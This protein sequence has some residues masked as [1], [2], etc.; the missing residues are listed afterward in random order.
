M[1]AK[2]NG[3]GDMHVA[4]VSF[5]GLPGIVLGQNE[6]I[7]WGATTTYFDFSDV[8]LETLSPDGNGVMLNGEEVPFV[9]REF[10]FP[11][12]GMDDVVQTVLYVPHHGPVLSI[13]RDAGT[14][15]SMSW[16]GQ[17]ATTDFNFIHAMIVATSVE[18]ARVALRNS[19]TIGQNFVVAGRNGDIGWF[20]YSA[21]PQRPWV[22]E[23]LPHFLP[24]PG[25]GSAEWQGAVPYEDLPQAF[26][27]PAAFIATAN[28]DMTGAFGDG[29]PTNDNQAALQN[30][31]A[32]GY[33]HERIVDRLLAEETHSRES[34]ESILADVHSLI[35][36]R[37]TPALLEALNGAELSDGAQQVRDALAAWQFDCPTGLAGTEASSPA[38]T[39][40]AVLSEA[41]GCSAFHALWTRV[42]GLTFSDELAAAG[43]SGS[44]NDAAL[45]LA[46]T[47][48]TA[49]NGTY[50]D[51]VST[52]T[53]ETQAQVIAT[54]ATDAA[55]WLT[56]QTGAASSEWL[57]GRVHTVTLRADL[58]DTAGVSDF[59]NGPRANDG[60][61]YTV[62]VA[63]PRGAQ[64]LSHRSGAS[65]RYACR[66]E[67]AESPASCTI[68]IPG[69]QRNFPDD[70]YYGNLFDLWL[71][72][73]SFQLQF[74]LAVARTNAVESVQLLSVD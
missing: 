7:A 39:D 46:L 41:V 59:N 1:D 10:T 8:Y 64:D 61:L 52:D 40:T 25:D 53:V 57:W 23:S 5:A 26:N 27:P 67:S 54:A 69:G 16:T 18:E 68:Q 71:T 15:V 32:A 24:L 35:G 45:V 22:S 34:M 6:H 74:D 31:T 72:N 51:D 21:I 60:G 29:D 49:L 56:E 12:N 13:D 62:D 48:P 66:Y 33:R 20:P 42:R 43:L 19:T 58:L 55:S 47:D 65:M 70:P 14:A 28:N 2:T 73:T 36:E 17:R 63:N 3:S 9:E 50:W 37:T 38:V 11:V 44:G 30:F 4:G